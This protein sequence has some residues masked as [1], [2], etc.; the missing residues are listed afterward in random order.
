MNAIRHQKRGGI[1]QIINITHNSAT[2]EDVYH[3]SAENWQLMLKKC[4]GSKFTESGSTL[5]NPYPDSDVDH[6]F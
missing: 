2:V 5:P 6:C 1:V 3:C 4:L